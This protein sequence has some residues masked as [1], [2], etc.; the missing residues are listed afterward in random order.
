VRAVL[1]IHA[2]NTQYRIIY[3][4]I[5]IYKQSQ[6]SITSI[7]SKP[8]VSIIGPPDTGAKV[9]LGMGFRVRVMVMVMVMVRL[10]SGLELD[11]H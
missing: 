2:N 6:Q 10:Q 9:T 5:N 7:L 1:E 4:G 11:Y 3:T 8:G